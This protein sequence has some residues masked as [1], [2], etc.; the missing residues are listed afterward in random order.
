MAAGSPQARRAVRGARAE[1]ESASG[2]EGSGQGSG[3]APRPG[4]QGLE[5][6]IPA[7]GAHAQQVQVGRERPPPRRPQP[8]TVLRPGGGGCVPRPHPSHPLGGP[9]QT[10]PPLP[11]RCPHWLG[12]YIT[13][14][15]GKGQSGG[16]GGGGNSPTSV[17]AGHPGG[18]T[19]RSHMAYWPRSMSPSVP[20][21][22]IKGKVISTRWWL[23][24]S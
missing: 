14:L 3:G 8:T 13:G 19:A 23:V 16:G 6:S 4:R 9:P 2:S 1:A 18:K 7:G 11:T 10:P 5:G 24:I 12:S 22:G 15:P 21:S 20:F 17:L